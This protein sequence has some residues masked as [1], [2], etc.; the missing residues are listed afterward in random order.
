MLLPR[1]SWA[2]RLLVS[3]E[4]LILS[5]QYLYTCARGS[6]CGFRPMKLPEFRS[7]LW[8]ARSLV[9]PRWPEWKYERNAVRMS[10]EGVWHYYASWLNASNKWIK[11][12]MLTEDVF[13]ENLT[14]NV[15]SPQNQKKNGTSLVTLVIFQWFIL[16]KVKT[17]LYIEP[18]YCPWKKTHTYWSFA[19]TCQ[20]I[21]QHTNIW[22]V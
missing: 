21:T 18:C 20:D 22:F 1:S 16:Y 4:G 5:L 13:K 2:F 7:K 8:G 14:K 15:F 17:I 11:L 9:F 6:S 3:I 12:N 10:I 19:T